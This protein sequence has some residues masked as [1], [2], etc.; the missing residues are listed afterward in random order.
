VFEIR[1]SF[2]ITHTHNLLALRAVYISMKL[3]RL[4]KN[5]TWN[6]KLALEEFHIDQL[7]YLFDS[8]GDGILTLQDMQA[9]FRSARGWGKP[10]FPD[11]STFY[12]V[13]S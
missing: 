4:K 3:P 2:F 11:E 5:R 7:F 12:K 6:S 8:D 9:L 13:P 1:K 10:I